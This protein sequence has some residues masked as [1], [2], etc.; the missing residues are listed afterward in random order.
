MKK[1][2]MALLTGVLMLVCCVIPAMAKEKTTTYIRYSSTG[3]A[4]YGFGASANA[5]KGLGLSYTDTY[6]VTTTGGTEA[7][8]LWT[9]NTVTMHL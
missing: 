4:T 7:W 9:D 2:I 3:S 6:T 8:D 1:K 5:E